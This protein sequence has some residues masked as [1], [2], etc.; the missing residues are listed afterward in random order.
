N[1]PRRPWPGRLGD[2]GVGKRPSIAGGVEAAVARA[3]VDRAVVAERGLDDAAVH[4]RQSAALEYLESLT[5][6]A[7]PL[8]LLFHGFIF[9][10]MAPG[11]S[12]SSPRVT[13]MR[14]RSEAKHNK[15]A[16][17]TTISEPSLTSA[18]AARAALVSFSRLDAGDGRGL[19]ERIR[20]GW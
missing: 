13:S 3:D 5:R 16:Q 20:R 19:S 10:G 2:Q 9:L 17:R 18:P 4:L 15:A 8:Q 7:Q 1:R 14:R 11:V 12:R 6:E